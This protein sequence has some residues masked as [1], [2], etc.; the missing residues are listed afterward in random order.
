MLKSLVGRHAGVNG[1]ANRIRGSLATGNS[2]TQ[3]EQWVR[4]LAFIPSGSCLRDKERHSVQRAALFGHWRVHWPAATQYA[5]GPKLGRVPAQVRGALSRFLGRLRAVEQ[6]LAL[7]IQI[8]EMIRLKS[9]GENTK[10]K[11]ARQ[12][13]GRSPTKNSVPTLPEFTD[14]E[15]AQLWITRAGDTGTSAASQ[16]TS[17]HGK[18]VRQRPL[19]TMTAS[20]KRTAF[21]AIPRLAGEGE[22]DPLNRS[23]LPTRGCRHIRGLPSVLPRACQLRCLFDP[24][25]L[26]AARV[27][28][29]DSEGLRQPIDRR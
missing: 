26:R 5:A 8:S 15:I 17:G 22:I 4:I 12:V 10:Q 16:V 20:P 3:R 24:P 7:A 29:S 9:V 14:V 28:P 6:A 25:A 13:N 11:V 2:L 19:M 21:W 27:S 1:A 18:P 23:A